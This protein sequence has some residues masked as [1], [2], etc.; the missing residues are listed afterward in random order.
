MKD[1]ASLAQP[2]YALDHG[3]PGEGPIRKGTAI[4]WT[5]ELSKIKQKL[6]DTIVSSAAIALPDFGRDAAPLIIS[7]DASIKGLGACNE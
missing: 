6:V 2:L 3:E 5:A 1:F 4:R 7:G